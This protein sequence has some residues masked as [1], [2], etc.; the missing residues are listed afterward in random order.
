MDANIVS[1]AEETRRSVLYDFVDKYKTDINN[2]YHATLVGFAN[3]LIHILRD[4]GEFQTSSMVTLSH[5]KSEKMDQVFSLIRQEI[6][7]PPYVY[8]MI[9]DLSIFKD[10][11]YIKLTDRE[12]SE[13]LLAPYGLRLI[14]KGE[15]NH[16]TI[17]VNLK[18]TTSDFSVF[19]ETGLLIK[20]F[21]SPDL[22]T[23]L[24]SINKILWEQ[25]GRQ[26]GDWDK[27]TYVDYTVNTVS[28]SILNNATLEQL[29]S[30]IKF[31]NCL[32]LNKKLLK[33]FNLDILSTYYHCIEHGIY[34]S[35][36]SIYEVLTSLS[37]FKAESVGEEYTVEKR[38]T[39]KSIHDNLSDAMF[40]INFINIVFSRA[41]NLLPKENFARYQNVEETEALVKSQIFQNLFKS[42]IP[43]NLK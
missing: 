37:K 31:N 32:L 39:L 15:K 13:C 10:F 4:T 38:V 42:A 9:V 14:F 11:S 34:K 6:D 17:Y 33:E 26:S 40:A 27:Q 36:P 30:S 12:F 18:K 35:Y 23:S 21:E 43:S 19:S 22:A 7:F 25:F 3:Y 29:K 1:K 20:Y 16:R 2:H 5:N 41:K 24:H 28:R 8:A